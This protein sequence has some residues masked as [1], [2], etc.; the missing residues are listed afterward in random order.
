ML[1]F[2]YDHSPHV[3]ENFRIT[4]VIEIT[5]TDDAISGR[6]NA[7]GR[8]YYRTAARRELDST[9][10]RLLGVPDTSN[11]SWHRGIVYDSSAMTASY[12]TCGEDTLADMIY[13]LIILKLETAT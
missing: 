3:I 12:Y 5:F 8:A 13:E 6:A 10:T 11:S 9:F 4:H 2:K 7:N 1:S